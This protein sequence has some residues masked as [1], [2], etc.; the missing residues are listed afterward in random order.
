MNVHQEPNFEWQVELGDCLAKMKDIPENSVSLVYLDPPFFTQKKQS[1]KTRD[2]L[3]EFSF[4]DIWSHQT[5]Y[6][7]YLLD[8]LEQMHRLLNSAGS[9]FFHCDRNAVHLARFL[10]DEVFGG[11]NFQA[12]IIWSYKRWS[13]AK[14]GLLQNHQNILFYSKTSDF[15]FNTV[16]TPYS[17]TTNV[18]QLLQQ[19]RRDSNGKVVYSRD[20]NGT[21]VS[22]DPK[23]GVPLGDVWDIPYLNPKANERVGYPTQKPI[24]LL[25]RIISIATN[26][27]DLVLDPF[28]GS[29]TTLVASRL[30]SRKAIGFD[31]SADAIALAKERL[32]NPVK[33]SSFLLA[34]GRDSYKNADQNA[35]TSLASLE[36]VE[37]QRNAGM[38]AILKRNFD[39][40]P[41]PVRVQRCYETL[42]EAAQKLLSAGRSKHSKLMILVRTQDNPEL[43]L[44]HTIP[45]EVIVL[46]SLSYQ[47]SEILDKHLPGTLLKFK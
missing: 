45:D 33:S 18:D 17:E 16:Y 24:L 22:S 4:E 10:L 1:L 44:G 37:V 15:T 40:R 13:N 41:I 39:G 34:N 23:L 14:K 42:T 38:D 3:K 20:T 2:N 9:I 36:I 32:K 35:L 28:C 46:D 31:I 29:G 12:E 11:D 8:R 6:A 21:V 5:E 25:E 47:L 19:R 27:N 30:L 7:K 26:E 43:L